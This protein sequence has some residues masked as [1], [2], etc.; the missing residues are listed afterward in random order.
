[1]L[2]YQLLELMK[3]N[4][5]MINLMNLRNKVLMYLFEDA[6]KHKKN[7]IFNIKYQSVDNVFLYSHLCNMFEKVG[8]DIFNTDIIETY[9]KLEKAYNQK[10]DGLD[11]TKK[12]F[13]DNEAE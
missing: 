11:T 8:I 3:I 6:A 4:I 10:N 7:E 1:M 9:K 2:N 13:N 5:L 12:V